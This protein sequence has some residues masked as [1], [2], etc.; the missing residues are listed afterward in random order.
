[1]C[2]REPACETEPLDD[3][4]DGELARDLRHE[5]SALVAHHR[6]ARDDLQRADRRQARDQLLGHAVGEVLLRRIAR[7]VLEREHR[8][9]A[10][11]RMQRAACLAVVKRGLP[12]D[13]RPRRRRRERPRRAR[14]WPSA[15]TRV[16]RHAGRE[17]LVEPLE[18]LE[19]LGARAVALL[20]ILLEAARDD[21]V[22]AHGDASAQ[23]LRPVGGDRA[24]ELRHRR[25]LDRG[26]RPRHHLVED[27]AER[28][29]CRRE[30]RPAG[31]RSTSGGRW[32]GV[33]STTP[34]AVRLRS[35]DRV[36]AVLFVRA[37]SR[38]RSRGSS[39]APRA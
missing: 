22:N 33:P 13:E 12:R 21:R 30:R 23:R 9:R 6:R 29:R 20:G 2:T 31:P 34:A 24:R 27:D 5:R 17:R 4:V 7:Q 25:P 19:R 37:A 32:F 18:R 14:R 11:L 16:R 15:S 35:G 10:D 39:R 38:A 1:M 36:S 26:K 8:E 28:P 3:A